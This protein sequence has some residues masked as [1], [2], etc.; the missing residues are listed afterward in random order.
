MRRPLP[1]LSLIIL[2]SILVSAPRAPFG[3]V[4]AQGAEP[5]PTPIEEP[6]PVIEPIPM[7][8]PI[9]LPVTLKSYDSGQPGAI[10]TALDGDHHHHDRDDVLY[11]KKR[12]QKSRRHCG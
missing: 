6:T 12:K 7:P 9:F 10:D 2:T 8:E 11:E 5:S 3:S 4:R 1:L